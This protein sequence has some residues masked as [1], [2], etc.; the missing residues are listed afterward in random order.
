MH[1]CHRKIYSMCC[2]IHSCD[3]FALARQKNWKPLQ[4]DLTFSRYDLFHEEP[5]ISKSSHV[6]SS[7]ITANR[8]GRQNLPEQCTSMPC[9]EVHCI[10][11]HC[12]ILNWTVIH[13][14]A[15]QYKNKK[16]FIRIVIGFF[17]YFHIL[18][19]IA[20]KNNFS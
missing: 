18:V 9:I 12:T 1:I 14:T 3:S 5:I 19:K 20:K 17:V 10:A 13:Y 4:N 2:S 8:S 16:W 6:S 11:L 7:F 15:L